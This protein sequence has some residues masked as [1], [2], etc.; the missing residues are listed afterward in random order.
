MKLQTDGGCPYGDAHMEDAA[1]H[2][3]A[4]SGSHSEERCGLWY[5][6]LIPILM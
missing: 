2:D 3:A 1:K 4:I 5:R 6:F